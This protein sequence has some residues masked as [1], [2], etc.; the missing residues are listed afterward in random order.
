MLHKKQLNKKSYSLHSDGLTQSLISAWCECPQKF[1]YKINRWEGFQRDTTNFGTLFHDALEMIYN[2]KNRAPTEKD[3]Y[4]FL[5]DHDDLNGMKAIVLLNEYIKVYKGDFKNKR[6]IAVEKVF[7]VP[8]NGVRLRGKFDG[9]YTAKDGS[10]WIIEHKTKSQINEDDLMLKLSFDFQN[11]FYI[12]CAGI[13][14]KKPIA[15]IL[16]NVIRNPAHK[17]GAK[18]GRVDFQK[19]LQKEVAENPD[20]FF[21]RFE[22]PYTKKQMTMF[23]EK[24][25]PAKIES[26]ERRVVYKNQGACSSPFRCSFLNACGTGSMNGY[27]A[28]KDPFSE[29]KEV[30]GD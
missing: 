10:L 30:K 5:E 7:D 24:E 22:V 15:G 14:Y 29:L 4:D 2:I 23:T 17:Q 1:E 13:H 3:I 16:Y 18:E 8:Y 12:V 28:T 11:Q 25:L 19:R 20:H 27:T 6:F 9:L 26:I 21:K